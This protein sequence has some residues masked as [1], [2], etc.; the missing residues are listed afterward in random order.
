MTAE[1]ETEAR[2]GESLAASQ[3]EAADERFAPVPDDI[4]LEVFFQA[5]EQ[6]PIAISITDPHAHIIYANPAFHETTGYLPDEVKGENESV[7]SDK[8]TP[9]KLYQQLWANLSQQ[10]G[11]S[12]RLV[13]RRKDGKRYLAELSASPVVNQEGATSNFLGIHRDVTQQHQLT[14]EVANQRALIRSLL[15][16]AP[17]LIVALDELGKVAFSNEAYRLGARAFGGNDR[18]ADELRCALCGPQASSF[19][20]LRSRTT[21]VLARELSLSFPNENGERAYSCSARW[22]KEDDETADGFFSEQGKLYFLIFANNITSL[23]RQQEEVRMNTLR[24]LVSEE[25]RLQEM[26]ETLGAAIYQFQMPLNLL[27]SAVK[28]LSD[29]EEDDELVGA[30]REVLRR[31]EVAIELL[32]ERIPDSSAEPVALLDFNEVVRDVIHLNAARLLSLDVLVEWQPTTLPAFYGR[33]SRIRLMFKQLL[34]NAIEALSSSGA[35]EI[36]VA[37][38]ITDNEK[39]VLTVADSGPGIADH[40]RLKV[41]E[42]FFTT[43]QKT[44][45][46]GMGLSLAQ[47]VVM[48]HAGTI[49]VD[50]SYAA[51]CKIV[52][53]LPFKPARPIQ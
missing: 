33:A 35:R 51:G 39:L 29:R 19:V 26:Q 45:G 4:P 27:Q 21:P 30:L 8:H 34:D 11:W 6:A 22:L 37:T 2:E 32:R 31:G 48:E 49:A 14:R 9:K 47:D 1:T 12:G 46:A 25:H 44:A 3:A 43:K 36:R 13:N 52:V 16:S 5:V 18:L 50:S 10:K 20:R 23:R 53:S 40:L 41:F 24:A 38:T 7:L 42:P 17:T 28:L 15:E